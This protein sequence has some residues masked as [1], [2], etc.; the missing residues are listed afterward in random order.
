MGSLTS[1]AIMTSLRVACFVAVISTAVAAQSPPTFDAASVKV[2]RSG[3]AGG[4]FGGQPGQVQVTNYTLRDIIRN[5]YNLQPYQLVGGPSWITADRFDIIARAPEGAPPARMMEMMK[6]LLADRFTL[7]VHTETRTVPIYAL[8]L[9]RPDGKLGPKM[10]PAAV[11][12]AALRA[13]R[14]RG[15]NPAMPPP[16]GNRP[17]CGMNTAFGRMVAG[18]Y[19]LRDVA[20]N[21]ANAVGRMVVD[22]TGLTGAY[23]LEM[24]WTPDQLPPG[25]DAAS[26]PAFDPNGPSLFTALQEQL[27]LRLEATTGPVDVLVIDGAERPSEN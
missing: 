7:R 15:E 6:T 16:T 8:V 14:E 12:C 23:D 27:G 4:R 13:A 20:R 10:T 5:V 9:A 24:T 1:Q 11:D 26:T 22:R 17:A 21:L 19:E 3:V 2:N 18:G 25:A